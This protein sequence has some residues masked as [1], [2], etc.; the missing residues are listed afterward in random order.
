M[1]AIDLS[2]V[3]VLS[4]FTEIKTKYSVLFIPLVIM[5]VTYRFVYDFYQQ[6]NAHSTY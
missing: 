5:T 6:P 4:I 1:P 3:Y 2:T